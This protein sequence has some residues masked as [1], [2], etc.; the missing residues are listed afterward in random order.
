MAVITVYTL[1]HCPHCEELKAFLRER[2]VL[3]TVM[4][5]DSPEG[6]TELTFNACFA[7]EA[8][9]LQVGDYFIQSEEL[10]PDGELDKKGVAFSVGV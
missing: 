4:R 2:G 9:V 7:M 5:M 1:E 8:P 6:R 10:F 3:Y